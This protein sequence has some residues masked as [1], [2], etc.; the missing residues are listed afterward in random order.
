VFLGNTLLK[1]VSL[2]SSA[3]RKS[4]VIPVA[5]FDTPR[6]GTV[7]IVVSSSDKTVRVEGLGVAT[8]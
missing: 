1:T 3:L 6:A 4:Q 8:R 7:R 5:T 2:K